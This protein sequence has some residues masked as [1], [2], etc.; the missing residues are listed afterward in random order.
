M[1]FLSY[2]A[3]LCCLFTEKRLQLYIKQ[4]GCNIATADRVNSSTTTATLQRKV[5]EGYFC[6][7]HINLV[8]IRV[9][10]LSVFFLIMQVILIDV[11]HYQWDNCY[12]FVASF[13]CG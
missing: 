12:I 8:I 11:L 10:E 4:V 3:Y 7:R 2:I 1:I 9:F 6:Y 13:I 5:M